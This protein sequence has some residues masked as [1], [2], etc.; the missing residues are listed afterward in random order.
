[1]GDRFVLIRS[2]SHKGRIK[3]GLKAMRNTGNEAKMREELAA[4]VAGV[5]AAVEPDEVYALDDE[6]LDVLVKAANLVTLARTGV[7]LDYRGNVIDAHDPEMPTRFAKQQKGP[8]YC[9]NMTLRWNPALVPANYGF[10]TRFSVMY[11]MM[12]STGG[13]SHPRYSLAGSRPCSTIERSSFA[14]IRAASRDHTGVWPILMKRWRSP[15][16]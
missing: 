14:L 16:R 9:F 1:M 12:L 8:P 7:E 6:D 2:D 10:V 3:S 15:M 5:V 11:W 13:I 4:A